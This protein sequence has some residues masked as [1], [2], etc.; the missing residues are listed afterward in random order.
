MQTEFIAL[1]W[2]TTSFRAYRVGNDGSILETIA[3]AEGI[4]A[5]KDG[6]FDEVLESHIGAWDVAT[7]IIASGMI[8]SRQGWVELPYVP[9]PASVKTIAAALLQHKTKRPMWHAAR[10]RKSLEQARVGLNTSSPRAPIAN[11]LM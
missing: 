3:A 9:C 2:G 4:M 1:D 11:G 8:T 6:A 5:V 10:K 7:P